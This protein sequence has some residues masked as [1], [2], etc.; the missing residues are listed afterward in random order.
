M[1]PKPDKAICLAIRQRTKKK[2]ISQRKD[3]NDCADAQR[4]SEHGHSGE[5]WVLT[6]L[7]SSKAEILRNIFQPLDPSLLTAVFFDGFQPTEFPQ[8]GIARFFGIHA[9]MDVLLCAHLDVRTHFCFH[10]RIEIA[11]AEQGLDARS[12]RF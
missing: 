7:P 11:F 3:R 4:E 1:L 2:M 12:D 6:Q 8:S 10:V 5:T 9:R